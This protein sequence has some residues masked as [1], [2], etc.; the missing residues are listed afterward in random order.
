MINYRSEGFKVEMV[1]QLLDDDMNLLEEEYDI[2]IRQTARL[3]DLKEKL[4]KLDATGFEEDVSTI[5]DRLFDPTHIDEI[6]GELEEL[7]ERILNQRIRSQ[8][9]ENAIKEW[10][11]MGKRYQNWRTL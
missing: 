11:G 1:E 2:F 9:I 4:F 6:E 8:K 5:S 7:K 10:T 3:K